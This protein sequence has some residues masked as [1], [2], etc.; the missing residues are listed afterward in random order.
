MQRLKPETR[1]TKRGRK[2]PIAEYEICKELAAAIVKATA[3]QIDEQT[4]FK[5]TY[6][7]KLAELIESA[8]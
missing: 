7:P 2:T 8:A 4:A 6:N 1:Q 5:M 3:G